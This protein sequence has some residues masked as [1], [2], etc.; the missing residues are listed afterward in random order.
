MSLI[1]QDQI[2]RI[3]K[4]EKLG[5]I[6]HQLS[7][8]IM[9][10]LS[11]KDIN[12]LYDRHKT[13][14][15]LNFIDAILED[16]NITI[17]VS[18]EDLTKIPKNKPFV[19][20]ANHPMGAIDGL[21]LLKILLQENPNAKIMANFL[22]S[23][24]E[25]IKDYFLEVNPFEKRKEIKSSYSGIKAAL[26][27]INEGKP[28]GIFPAGEVSTLS[29]IWYGSVQDR[30]WDLS[31]MKMIKKL[32][33]PVIPLYFD[34]KNSPAFYFLASINSNLRTASLPKEIINAKNKVVKLKIGHP[35]S[36]EQQKNCQSPEELRDM[37]FTRTY[38]LKNSI[39]KSQRQVTERTEE[40]KVKL[41][42]PI[43]DRPSSLRVQTE[44]NAISNSIIIQSGHYDLYYTPL[45]NAPSLLKLIGVEREHT[46]RAVGEGTQSAMDVDSFDLIYNHLIL[47]DRVNHKLVGA[48][49][50]G[51]GQDLI[52]GGYGFEKLYT[53]TLFKMDG[54]LKSFLSKCIE[55]GRSFITKEYQQKPTPL[56]I[57]WKGLAKI[58]LQNPQYQYFLGAASISNAYSKVSKSCMVMYLMHYHLD[59]TIAKYIEP[60]EPFIPRLTEGQQ[61]C[62]LNLGANHLKE[63]DK[64]ISEIDPTSQKMPILIKKY[65]SQ[66]AKVLAVNVDHN[67]SNSLDVLIYFDCKDIDQRFL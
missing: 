30:Q 33:I 21:I 29:K 48:Y 4:I 32:N 26:Q 5:K 7:G 17:D 27:Q 40:N 23:K 19:L 58:A 14:N 50:L 13:T 42:S 51:F 67:F 35:I 49:R 18:K 64:L 20:V 11:I 6:G 46:F 3:F 38:F 54:E 45:Y 28:L 34:V 39:V 8:G 36:V 43:A 55:I 60:N 53:T 63:M 57:L 37:L 52:K 59:Y 66:K 22:L 15:G 24:I 44:L 56:F 47:W 1:K 31:I 25:P 10:I 41:K 16:L 9:N 12:E 65:L 61:K 62:I 2:S